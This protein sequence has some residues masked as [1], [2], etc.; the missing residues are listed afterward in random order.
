[1]FS[2]LRSDGKKSFPWSRLGIGTLW[3]QPL[4]ESRPKKAEQLRPFFAEKT[5]YTRGMGAWPFGLLV[6]LLFTRAA[7]AQEDAPTGILH[8][9][10]EAWA[11]SDRAG[12]LTFRNAD[13]RLY[14]CSYDDKTYFERENQRI[15]VMATEKG[16]RVEIVSDRKLGTDACYA[17]TVQILVQLP[18]RVVPGVRSHLHQQPVSSMDLFGPRGDMTF[19]GVVLRLDSDRLV[20]RMRS[21]EHKSIL[22][23]PDTL[24]LTA[25][26]A[27]E[28]SS[29]AVT[30]RVFI[31]A[32]RNLDDKVEAFQVVWGEILEP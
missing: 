6:V 3:L 30:T 4:S 17:R 26:Q 15:S 11:G 12:E 2:R 1:V 20:L 21:G 10:F 7:L 25:G 18:V 14:Q 9:D 32:G 22:L 23:R 27:V 29:L 28:R 8:G 19:A 13:N 31:R 16:D 5:S 24:Y